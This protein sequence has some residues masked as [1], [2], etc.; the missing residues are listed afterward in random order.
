MADLDEFKIPNDAKF[1]DI[2]VPTMDT[3]RSTFV[4]ELLL[5]AQKTV[6]NHF[7]VFYPRLLT[8]VKAGRVR[9]CRVAGNT[10]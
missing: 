7:C 8:G 2:I 3:I 5:G 9:L 1:S 6:G 10:V 4:L